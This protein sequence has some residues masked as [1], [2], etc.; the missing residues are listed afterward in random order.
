VH[1]VGFIIRIYY[2]D[3]RSSECQIRCKEFEINI[4]VM[5]YMTPSW[6]ALND[7]TH[8]FTLGPFRGWQLWQRSPL[9]QFAVIGGPRACVK[10]VA[11]HIRFLQTIFNGSSKWLAMWPVVLFAAE[12]HRPMFFH[13]RPGV[14][15]WRLCEFIDDKKMGPVIIAAHTHTHTH[16][17]MSVRK[18]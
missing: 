9:F 15:K 11:V 5:W 4:R 12:R 3:A 14:K 17:H 18:R 13:Y 7:H 16:I 2:H 6:L 8:Y 1:L 10:Y